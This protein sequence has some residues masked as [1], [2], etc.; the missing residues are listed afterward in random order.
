MAL[1]HAVAITLGTTSTEFWYRDVSAYTDLAT[2]LT[3]YINHSATPFFFLVMGMSM[4]LLSSARRRQGW[5]ASRIHAFF[6]FRG[7]LLIA[8]QFT[9]VNLGWKI[10]E[11]GMPFSELTWAH[12]LPAWD[13]VRFHGVLFSLGV[14]MIAA[15]LLLRVPTVIVAVCATAVLVAPD[16]YLSFAEYPGITTEIPGW[17]GAIGFPGHWPD[18]FILYTPIPWLGMTLLGLVLGRVFL[19][20]RDRFEA[21]LIPTG[22]AALALFGL[23]M[24]GRF[25]IGDATSLID[26]LHLRRYP[27][28]L[29]LLAY[30]FG[31]NFLLLAALQR[32]D[33][34]ILDRLLV[35]F[36]RSAL[37]LYVSHLFVF[38]FVIRLSDQPETLTHGASLAVL[39]LA[40]MFPLCDMYVRHGRHAI[41]RVL[42]DLQR[43]FGLPV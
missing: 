1:G 27:P 9:V 29:L 22:L 37:F 38:A 3:R 15:S 18:A 43:S 14:S 25:V 39:S 41:R 30:A 20:D 5:S 7:A 6:L 24:I 36:G 34:G 2:F 28:H 33:L 12:L 8:L 35:T 11:G 19:A 4:V 21:L 32:F 40:V 17:I 26:A 13:G 16:I 10:A 42:R 23:T 31:V